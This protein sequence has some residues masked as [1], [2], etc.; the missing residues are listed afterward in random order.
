MVIEE[1]KE[2]KMNKSRFIWGIVCLALAVLLGVLYFTL[3]PE[4]FFFTVGDMKMP[5]LPPIILGI[6]G[7]ILLVSAFNNKGAAE[8]EKKTE[9]VQDPDKAP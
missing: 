7:I 2:V 1:S 5:Y 3:P 4:N 6:L 8:E 9:I